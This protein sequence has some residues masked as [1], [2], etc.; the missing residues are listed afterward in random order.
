MHL[1][2]IHQIAILL[3]FTT[4]D[5]MEDS[6]ILSGFQDLM[7]MHLIHFGIPVFMDL[8][9]MDPVFTD[10]H[11]MAEVSTE[12][13]VTDMDMVLVLVLVSIISMVDLD[14]IIPIITHI[15]DN[16]ISD[17]MWPIM[18]EDEARA[19]IIAIEPMLLEM[20]QI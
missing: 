6:T 19:A 1:G 13:M 18:L 10:L 5:S 17:K 9:S 2:V 14:G 3:I 20:Q 15:T 16:I 7:A 11:T 4:T 8:V 12:I